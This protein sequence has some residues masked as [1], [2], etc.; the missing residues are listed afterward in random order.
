MRNLVSEV[1]DMVEKQAN[2]LDR[3]N[4]LRN[5]AYINK[6]VGHLLGYNF[7]PS[8]EFL[9]PK[10]KPPFK[11]EGKPAGMEDTTLEKEFRR[12]Y[13]WLDSKQNLAASRREQLF[14]EMLGG[15]HMSEANLI[16]DVKDK[17]LQEKYPS[18]TEKLVR[19]TF[20]DLLPAAIIK[21]KTK[22]TKGKT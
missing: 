5:E 1:Y 13:I 8:V 15:L 7:N 22:K 3:L 21:E 2:D 10:G 6:V 19:E 12:F 4:L 18:I 11:N 20:P 17:K 16:C 14:I 9:L